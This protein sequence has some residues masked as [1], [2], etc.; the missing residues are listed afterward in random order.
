MK[1]WRTIPIIALALAM[2]DGLDS[3]DGDAQTAG[4]LQACRRGGPVGTDEQRGVFF[5]GFLFLFYFIYLFGAAD[6]SLVL[7]TDSRACMMQEGRRLLKDADGCRPFSLP[8]P[9]PASPTD[10]TATMTGPSWPSTPSRKPAEQLVGNPPDCDQPPAVCQVVH[11]CRTG[12]QAPTRLLLA[13]SAKAPERIGA[14]G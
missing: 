14:R 6:T 1:A 2:M 8:R 5:S 13:C 7:C 12:P 11:R 4:C 3:E 10:P 9:Y